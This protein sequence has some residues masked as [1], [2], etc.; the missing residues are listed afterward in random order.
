MI[1]CYLVVNQHFR[2]LLFPPVNNYL[3]LLIHKTAQE[4]TQL[5]S[6]SVGEGER[7]RTVVCWKQ[8]LKR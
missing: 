5:H 4:Y 6:F 7:R 1:M 2:V 3:R 8:S